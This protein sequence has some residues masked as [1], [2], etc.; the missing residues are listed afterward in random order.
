MD[1]VHLRVDGLFH[2]FAW[3]GEAEEGGDVLEEGSGGVDEVFEW[4]GD[5]GDVLVVEPGFGGF[6]LL[7][8]GFFDVAGAGFFAEAGEHSALALEDVLDVAFHEEDAVF[9][10]FG[11]F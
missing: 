1:A 9:E 11:E 8:V 4:D 6:D 2:G 10:F 5:G 7:V 3:V